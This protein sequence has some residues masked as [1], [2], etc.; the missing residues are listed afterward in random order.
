VK[1]D[2]E[3]RLE[4][5]NLAK[6]KGLVAAGLLGAPDDAVPS[7]EGASDEQEARTRST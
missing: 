7:G 5:K 6:N 1:V 3:V 4:K 2:E